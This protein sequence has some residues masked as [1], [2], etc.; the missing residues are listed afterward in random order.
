MNFEPPEIVI[1]HS[2]EDETPI[3]APMEPWETM[4]LGKAVHTLLHVKE[5]PF[6]Q[7][8][9]KPVRNCEFFFWLLKWR[10]IFKSFYFIAP[11]ARALYSIDNY[12]ASA[13]F[14]DVYDPL[15]DQ[16]R[17]IVHDKKSC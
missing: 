5:E 15:K 8:V 6:H 11:I 9:L 4:P 10:H 12:L 2:N 1:P 16:V 3:Q 14:A 13:R 17:S 7:A